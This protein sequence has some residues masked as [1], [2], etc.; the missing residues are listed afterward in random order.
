MPEKHVKPV[1]R[2]SVAGKFFEVLHSKGTSLKCSLKLCQI[3]SL[4]ISWTINFPLLF[5]YHFLFD[6]FYWSDSSW[7]VSGL[8]SKSVLKRSEWKVPHSCSLMSGSGVLFQDRER[9]TR[10]SLLEYRAGSVMV[11]NCGA[12]SWVTCWHHT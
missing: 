9:D 5:M 12:I 10:V 3:K 11:K 1:S 2:L 4:I 6:G 8:V 7:C